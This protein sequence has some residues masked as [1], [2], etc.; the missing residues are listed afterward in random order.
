MKTRTP[1]LILIMALLMAACGT[2]ADG[3]TTVPSNA[4]RDTSTTNGAEESPATTST[5]T[6]EVTTTTAAETVDGVRI[7]DSE[8]GEILV[9]PD[10]FTLYVFDADVDGESACYDACASLWP[11]VPADTPIDAG[12]D[13]ALFGTT[14]RTDGTDQL[15]VNGMP[16][17]RY[18]PD[19]APG[20]VT[21]QGLNGVW[22]VVDSGGNA[23]E[24]AAG[25]ELVI[26]YGY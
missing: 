17:Y 2:A 20:D 23:V 4:A 6:L 5:T 8:L 7:A 25:D 24:A 1:Y 3:D 10:G 14:S 22:W 11:P 18:T 19:A 15:T 12:L 16:L 26:D 9:D 21:G 13:S